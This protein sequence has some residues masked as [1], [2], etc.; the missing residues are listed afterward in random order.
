MISLLPQLRV[1]VATDPV[2]FR[3]GIDSLAALC[4]AHLDQDPFSGAL[5]VFRNRRG[6]SVKLLVYDG[7]GFWLC[8]RRFSRGRLRY[9]PH[10]DAPLSELAAAELSVVLFQGDPRSADFAPA[11]RRLASAAAQA[12]AS[13]EAH[14]SD[15]AVADALRDAHSHGTHA[16]GE[17]ATSLRWPTTSAR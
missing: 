3:R 8:L 12:A 15:A 5:F 17:A 13:P 4:R 10:G 14:G 16:S 1:L 9:W 7:I 11:W 6:T 2:D